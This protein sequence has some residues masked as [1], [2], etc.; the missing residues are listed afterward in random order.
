MNSLAAATPG[1]SGA[2]SRKPAAVKD[3]FRITTPL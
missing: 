1:D 2:P 3:H